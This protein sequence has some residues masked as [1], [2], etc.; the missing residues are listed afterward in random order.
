[1]TLSYKKILTHNHEHE[2]FKNAI[3]QLQK[4]DKNGLFTKHYEM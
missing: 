2:A 4:R 1:M 3:F